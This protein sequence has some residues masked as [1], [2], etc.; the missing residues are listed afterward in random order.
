MVQGSVFK[1]FFK[2]SCIFEYSQSIF[3]FL[4][5]TQKTIWSYMVYIVFIVVDQLKASLTCLLSL[6]LSHFGE[7]SNMREF[8]KKHLNTDSWTI[9]QTII[10]PRIWFERS[11]IGITHAIVYGWPL[12]KRLTVQRKLLCVV[13]KSKYD[14]NISKIRELYYT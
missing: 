9:Y 7:Y 12:M 3:S 2:N 1:W 4:Q 10:K 8:L 5:P 11:P 14:I 13:V 6:N